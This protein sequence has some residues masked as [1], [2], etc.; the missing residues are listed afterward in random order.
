MIFEDIYAGKTA[1][2]IG[3]RDSDYASR[4]A[5]LDRFLAQWGGGDLRADYVA[6]IKTQP[7]GQTPSYP[8]MPEAVERAGN[9]GRALFRFVVAGLPIETREHADA[10]VKICETNECGFYDGSVCRHTKCGCFTKIKT[11]LETEHCPI[12]KW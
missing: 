7:E 11:F 9:L 8:A 1:Q 6:W 2:Q 12:G 4:K 3:L 5:L 10:R